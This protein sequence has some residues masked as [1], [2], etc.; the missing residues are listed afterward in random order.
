MLTVF[1][2]IRPV[3]NF[4]ELFEFPVSFDVALDELD[5]RYLQ[6]QQQMHPD[7]FVKSTAE[8]RRLS[9]QHAARIN[10]AYQVLKSPLKRAQYLLELNGV[11]VNDTDTV[12]DHGFLMEQMELRETLEN[13]PQSEDP[14]ASLESFIRTADEFEKDLI[15]TLK[16]QF[17][18]LSGKADLLD[19]LQQ[20]AQTVKKLQFINKLKQEAHEL[21]DRLY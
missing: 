7:K 3:Q 14:Q 8:E 9:M 18:E 17:S 6:L 15:N 16:T 11:S 12:M 20:T 19:S 4:F 1:F 21:E 2:Q 10:D 5:K 13:I